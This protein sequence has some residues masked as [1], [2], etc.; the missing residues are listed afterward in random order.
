MAFPIAAAIALT[1]VSAATAATCPR[2]VDGAEFSGKKEL[3]ELTKKFNSFGPRILASSAHNKSIDWLE[4]EARGVDGFK[5]K[6]ESFKVYRWLPKAQLK[7]GPGLDIGGAGRL[8]VTQADGSTVKVPDAG[9]VHWSEP[10]G[11]QGQGGPLV[12]LHRAG[13]RHHSR[14]RRR[15]GGHSRLPDRFA[16]LHR[17]S[18]P[19]RHLHH[20]RPR[21]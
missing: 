18:G 15:Q 12:Y 16:S 9:A 21:G 13:R 4:D 2:V 20:T 5:T 19:A 14:E 8:S 11:K 1:S 10:T 6:S 7:G 17:P 3:R